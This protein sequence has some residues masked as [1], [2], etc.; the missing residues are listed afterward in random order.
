MQNQ[1]NIIPQ[2]NIERL[3]TQGF[4]GYTKE[5]LSNHQFG[6]RFAYWTCASFVAVG[7]ILN[8]IP[9]LT[10]ALLAALGAVVHNRHPFDYIYNNGVRQLLKKPKSPKRAIQGKVACAIASLHIIGIIY[11]FYNGYITGGYIISVMLL[12]PALIVASTDYCIP[13]VAFSFLYKNKAK[14]MSEKA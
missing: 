10:I 7:T 4:T 13:S 1:K 6:I 5:E 11:C 3:E 8:N 2:K 12:I 14:Q 9:I